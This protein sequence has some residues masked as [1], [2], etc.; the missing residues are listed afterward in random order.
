V[1]GVR[2]QLPQEDLLVA[3]QGV[4][5]EVEQ[6]L[7]FGL[8]AQ[9]LFGRGRRHCLSPARNSPDMG[10][11]SRLFKT[12]RTAAGTSI[13]LNIAHFPNSLSPQGRTSMLK[14][15]SLRPSTTNITGRLVAHQG[16]TA[17]NATSDVVLGCLHV[18]TSCSSS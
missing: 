9:G 3:V 2:Y 15:Y 18:R 12:R 17:L 16:G 1:V 7:D 11:D 13:F 8:E 14:S 6:L 4:D 10:L 5:H